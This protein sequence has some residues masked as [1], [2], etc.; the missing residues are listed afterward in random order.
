M[1][2]F[3]HRSISKS[4]PKK[5]LNLRLNICLERVWIYIEGF[6]IIRNFRLNLN[7]FGS[8]ESWLGNMNVVMESLLLMRFRRRCASDTGKSVSDA[9]KNASRIKNIPLT[10]L[11]KKILP[12]PRGRDAGGDSAMA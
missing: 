1:S 4:P 3:C 7:G 12:T 6:Y 11:T 8:G 2:F 9:S 10:V 5:V